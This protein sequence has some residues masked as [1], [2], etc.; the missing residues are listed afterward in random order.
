MAK[1]RFVCQQKLQ[2]MLKCVCII[3]YF[4]LTCHKCSNNKVYFYIVDFHYSRDVLERK[5]FDGGGFNVYAPLQKHWSSEANCSFA[6]DTKQLGR[7][8]ASQVLVLPH[9]QVIF[10]F[11]LLKW[12]QVENRALTFSIVYCCSNQ[13]GVTPMCYK[14]HISHTH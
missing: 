8:E 14:P 2:P 6:K 5:P 10:F 9:S 13:Y 1:F 7:I 3:T 12:Y 4:C 11:V